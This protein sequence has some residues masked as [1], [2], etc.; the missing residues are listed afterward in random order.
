MTTHGKSSHPLYYT[1]KNMI[2]RCY[3]VTHPSYHQ[4]GGYGVTV[5]KEWKEDVAAFIEWAENNGYAKGKHLDKDLGNIG[6]KLYSPS[7]CRFIDR[8]VNNQATRRISTANTSGYRGSSYARNC[9]K[10]LAQIKVNGVHTA[11]GYYSTALAAAKAYDYYIQIHKLN[12]TINGVLEPLEVIDLSK[13][14]KPTNTSGVTGVSFEKRREKWVA[15]VN[16]D[17]KR[18]HLGYFNTREEAVKARLSHNLKEI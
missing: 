10:W 16:V 14:L 9:D 5:C 3:T 8:L 18:K 11:I 2:A 17:K 1:W 4:Y 13:P 6:A 7:T 12:H 15:Y